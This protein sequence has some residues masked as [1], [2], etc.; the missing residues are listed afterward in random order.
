MTGDGSEAAGSFVAD[1]AEALAQHIPVK[2]VAPGSDSTHE[3]VSHQ[4]EIFRFKA[5]TKPLSTLRIWHPRDFWQIY[6]VLRHGLSATQKA[7]ESGPIQHILALWALP[8]GHWARRIS[9]RY[10]IPYSVWTLGSDIWSLGRIPLLRSYLKKI[11]QDATACYSDGLQLAQDTQNIAGRAVSFLPSTRATLRQRVQPL[12]QNPPYRLLFLGRWHPNKG[13]DLLLEALSQLPEVTWS[14]ILEITIAGGGPL[15]AKV[16]AAVAELQA[17]GRPIVLRGF[18]NKPQAEEAILSADYL[19]IPSRIESIPVVFSDAVK[20]GCPVLAT[21][22]GDLPRLIQNA[23]N[24]GMVSAG[25]CAS[26]YSQLMIKAID[27]SPHIF[28]EGIS[29]ARKLFDIHHIANAFMDDLKQPDTV[30]L[31]PDLPRWGTLNRDK[32]A[33]AI[34]ATL[35]AQH[36]EQILLGTWLD[37]GCGSGQ[38]SQC[39]ANRVT[40]MIGVDPEPWP[41]WH[42]ATDQFPNLTFVTSAFDKQDTSI[43]DQSIDVAICNQVYEHV[44]DAERLLN[45]IYRVLKPSGLC[46]FAGPNLL[47]PIEPHVYW[48]FVHWIPRPWAIRIMK[49]ARSKKTSDLDAYSFSYWHLVRLFKNVGLEHRNSIQQRLNVA[50]DSKNM[51]WLQWLITKTPTPVVNALTPFSPGFVFVLRR[52]KNK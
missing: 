29:A 47:W 37:I 17:H 30:S 4:L 33:A 51:K 7:V 16:Q 40:H 32:K 3:R 10:Q 38:I 15:A 36:A 42:K 18:L 13:I 21:P 34:W 19:L 41:Q 8:S 20:L 52:P 49:T 48:P 24:C 2:I 45:N 22:V 26:S 35:H 5:P 6:K 43:Q 39:F 44:Q 9:R 27:L 28:T 12:S 50:L 11:L 46:Y 31:T 1:W 23:P 14:R 25:V